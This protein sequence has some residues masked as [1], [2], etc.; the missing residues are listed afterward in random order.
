M[1]DVSPGSPEILRE[2]RDTVAVQNLIRARRLLACTIDNHRAIVGRVSPAWI[3]SEVERKIPWDRVPLLLQKR[4]GSRSGTPQ[5]RINTNWLPKLEPELDAH[6]LAGVILFGARLIGDGTP[7]PAL[8]VSFREIDHDLVVAAM[9]H[10]TF[11]LTDTHSA[12]LPERQR[13][14]D[15]TFLKE[16][17]G[18][19]VLER[20]RALREQLAI[21]AKTLER[22][23]VM[24]FFPREYA[25]AI[26]AILVARLRLTART[27][28]DAIFSI[29]DEAKRAE[30]RSAGFDPGEPDAAFPE[31]PYLERDYEAARTAIALP[32]VDA[33][34][35][36]EPARDVLLRGIEH[37]LHHGTAAGE[38]VGKYGSAIRN[39][40]AALPLWER[41]SPIVRR[42]LRNDA[43]KTVEVSGPFALG[44]LYRTSLEVTRYLHNV[45]RK[46]GGTGA[47]H[48]FLVSARVERLLDQHLSI[49][50]IAGSD[51][52]DVVEDGGVAVAGYDQ[53][54]ELF[55]LRFG[56][57]LAAL[58]AELTDPQSKED[59][60]LKAGG[61]AA[62]PSLVPMEKVYNLGQLA[63][64]H[65]RAT[66]PE[67]PFTLEGIIMKLADFGSTQEEGLRDPSLMT[68]PWLQS[69]ARV[70]WDHT[71][72]GPI[73]HT[74][75]ARLSVE[76]ALSRSD[77]FYPQR[78]GNLPAHLVDRLRHVLQYS[79]DVADLYVAQNLAI[80]A[81]EYRLSVDQRQS[82]LDY[83]LVSVH[84]A[85]LPAS[86]LDELLDED[87]LDAEVRRKGLAATHRLV[88]N[89]NPVRDLSRLIDY[90]ERARWRARTREELGL[91]PVPPASVAEVLRHWESSRA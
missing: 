8:G 20:V 46:S 19:G 76:I 4:L 75:L 53:N 1:S 17:F 68:G 32:G 73:V 85:A 7:D 70:F 26:A 74:L 43:G 5:N 56:A 60:P 49:P 61:T 22:D 39:F 41:Y 27:A 90:R 44:T 15:E 47:G 88:P 48:S 66:D 50:L 3:L 52:H 65:S 81:N 86:F 14:V 34:T 51:C 21:F 30:L 71:S 25:N 80:L 12:F 23:Q 72:K 10:R 54:L 59:G 13:V 79:F 91:R 42:T 89:D 87:R 67:T 6:V 29:L 24:P 33:E 2:G 28:G 35:I 84:E 69:G 31:R 58:V 64:L 77:P 63:E 18:E 40:H 83:F 9:I 62:H 16:E 82:L 11:G 45:R 37:V 78:S 55:A 57:P 36:V 38:L